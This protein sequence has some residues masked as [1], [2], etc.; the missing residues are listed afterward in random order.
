VKA[1]R[2]ACGIPRHAR[3]IRREAPLVT[4]LA[5][6]FPRLA[7][8][9]PGLAFI[10]AWAAVAGCAGEPPL[11]ADVTSPIVEAG[12]VGGCTEPSHNAFPAYGAR[13]PYTGSPTAPKKKPPCALPPD[14]RDAPVEGTVVL[15][16]LVCEHGRVAAT[17]VIESVPMLD[18]AATDCVRLWDFK[19]AGI[20]GVPI[21]AWTRATVKFSLR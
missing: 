14:A 16:A 18:A 10:A 15:A 17:R 21:A 13:V 2:L 9:V 4:G 8:R 5:R 6:G 12:T 20:Q 11:P 3:G 1:G 7:S 19:P